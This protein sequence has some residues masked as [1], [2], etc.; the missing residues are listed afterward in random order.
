MPRVEEIFWVIWRRSCQP[1]APAIER[2][3]LVTIGVLE[4]RQDERIWKLHAAWHSN[5]H[6]SFRTAFR[7]DH[8][9][10]ISGGRTIESCRRRTCQNADTFNIV[11]VNI[12]NT[13]ATGLARITAATNITT[14]LIEHGN[15]IYHIK[16]IVATSDRFR[17]TH[18]YTGRSSYT[19]CR[20]IDIHSGHSTIQTVHK[21]HILHVGKLVA[22]NLLHIVTQRFFR[23]FNTQ[24]SYH[25]LIN[26]ACSRL[27]GDVKVACIFNLHLLRLHTN[28]TH[29]ECTSLRDINHKLTINVRHYAMLPILYTHSCTNSRLPCVVNN[30]SGNLNITTYLLRSHA[31][32]RW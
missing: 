12:R 13:F 32:H 11:G 3:C 16:N 4:L 2:S 18:N 9:N 23:A 8:D 30:G 14:T 17:T 31:L 28:I 5:S 20:R 7:I 15:T 26:L 21:V 27:H 24:S 29:N 19:S 1:V 25:N 22:S 6:L 10:T